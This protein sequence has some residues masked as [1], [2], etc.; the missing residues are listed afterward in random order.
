MAIKTYSLAKDGNTNVST[1]FK[2]KEFRCQDGSDMIKIDTTLVT[3]LE[4]IRTNCGNKAVTITSGYRTASHNTAVGGATNSQH[5][6]G[7]AA[8][9]QISGYTPSQVQAVC[10]KIM[11]TGGLGTASSFTHVDTRAGSLVVF[12]Y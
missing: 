8:D 1:N 12:T 10:K 6:Y 2:V 11:T 9:I 5:L 4:K 3:L 7:T